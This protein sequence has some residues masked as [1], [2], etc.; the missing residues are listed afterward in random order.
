M[1]KEHYG[2]QYCQFHDIV[3]EKACLMEQVFF[4]AHVVHA[5]LRRSSNRLVVDQPQT[6]TQIKKHAIEEDT[7]K[8]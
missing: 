3:G 7:Q 2:A 8:K 5:R 6:Q 1:Q 4:S